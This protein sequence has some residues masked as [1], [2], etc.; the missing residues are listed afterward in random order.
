MTQRTVAFFIDHLGV[1]GVQE[2]LLNFCK[3]RRDSSTIT[4]VSLFSNDAYA[5]R[6]RKAGATVIFL[7][8]KPY[9]YRSVLSVG[10][11]LSFR[12]F[13]L[14]H[15]ASFDDIHLKLFATF[16]YA[17]MMRLWRDPRVSAGLDANRNQHPLPIQALFWAF[18]RRYQRFYLNALLW[19]DYTAFGLRPPRLRDQ[20]YPVTR[21]QSD[22]PK[23]Y[24]A[25][26]SFVSVGR[27]IPQKGHAE[28]TAL[29]ELT[30]NLLDG[31]A[32]LAIIG[33]GPAVDTL[34][35]EHEAKSGGSI[36]FPGSVPNYDDWLIGASGVIRMAF[37]EDTNSVVR[38]AVLAGK[39]VATTLEG[40]GCVDLAEKGAVIA[41]DRDDLPGSA[42][43]L[44][45]AVRNMTPEKSDQLR[46]LAEKLWPE[47][48]AFRAYD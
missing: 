32:C 47:E 7:S 30:R 31:E 14:Q 39:V 21:R 41:I 25:K 48:Q 46:Q 9:S 16:A 37:G 15:N 3:A 18:A 22:T 36:A 6:L 40:P 43:R 27:G 29:F 24:P 13:Y 42:A 12:A 20:I 34:R 19:N 28:A 5:A 26:F 33:E 8:S 44:A 38:E 11:F 35:V 23:L 4:I 1:G 17:A 45:A 10:S 2:F